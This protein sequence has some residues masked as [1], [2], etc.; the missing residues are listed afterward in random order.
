M[1]ILV[2]NTPVEV[3]LRYVDKSFPGGAVGARAFKNQEEEEEWIQ[4]ENQRRNEKSMELEALKKEVPPI[5]K[6]DAKE[7]VKELITFWKRTDW[8]TQ[9]SIL[10]DSTTTNEM[11]ESRHDY[12]KYRVLQMERLMVGWNLKTADG[13]PIKI[14]AEVLSRLDFNVALALL[15]KYDE[16]VSSTGEEL[17]NLE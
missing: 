5:L 7:Q 2:D 15:D 4:K 16:A 9:T 10:D 13:N 3:R 12:T 17:E 8:G 6:T 11:G 1:P 14:N